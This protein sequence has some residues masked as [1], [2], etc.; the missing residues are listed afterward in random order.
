MEDQKPDLPETAR[1]LTLQPGKKY[2]L[3][4]CGQSGRLPYCDNSHKKY[5]EETGS[6]YRSFK[7]FPQDEGI[8][9][10]SSSNW[11]KD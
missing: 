8:F 7:I 11:K 3:C 6:H 5:N 4:T 9:Y 10:V 1:E 2:S